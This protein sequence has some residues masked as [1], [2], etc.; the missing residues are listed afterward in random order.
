MELKRM[1]EEIE[2]EITAMEDAIK[3]VMGSKETLIA[4]AYKVSWT[5]FTTSRFDSTAFR[6]DHA[7]LAAAYT[8]TATVRRFT[9]R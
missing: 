3:A 9:V 6:K 1:K 2:Q 8:K 4:G 7:D 5:P